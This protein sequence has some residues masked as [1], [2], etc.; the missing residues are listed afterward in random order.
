MLGNIADLA[1]PG[2]NITIVQVVAP[3]A[4][5]RLTTKVK[6]CTNLKLAGFCDVKESCVIDLSGDEDTKADINDRF[7]GASDYQ[8][9]EIRCKKPDFETGSS[10]P[11]SFAS[12]IQAKKVDKKAVWN[13][14]DD[15]D[16]L[17]DPDT[18]IDED[19]MKKPAESSLRGCINWFSLI[20]SHVVWP[21]SFFFCSLRNNREAKSLQGL[22]LWI[23]WRVGGG[24]GTHKEI[25]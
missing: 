19:D 23:G 6:L 1:K 18:L 8:V 5:D 13:L 9:V 12:K 14:D 20:E 10:Q 21:F 4:T 7:K 22:F 2:A 11:L 24:Q 3:S 25:R 15:D 16:D 17:V